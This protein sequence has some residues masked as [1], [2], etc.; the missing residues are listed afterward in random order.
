MK[1]Q[2]NLLTS[3]VLLSLYLTACSSL[4]PSAGDTPTGKEGIVLQTQV[5]Q[6]GFIQNTNLLIYPGAK[7]AADI[8]EAYVSFVC[9]DNA[10]KIRDFY[11]KELSDKGWN[12]N[13][14]WT[15]NAKPDVP[16]GCLRLI[17]QRKTEVIK[18]DCK[19]SP[20]DASKTLIVPATMDEDSFLKEHP[21]LK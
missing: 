1:G 20:R 19:P 6:G 17:A 3:A 5:G 21:E 11:L 12:V 18:I 16:A 7:G 15:K 8:G 4:R 10:E 9:T 2:V 13:E 14:V